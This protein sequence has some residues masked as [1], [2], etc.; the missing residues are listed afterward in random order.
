MVIIAG[1][2]LIAV[3]IKAELISGW[4]KVIHFII[5]LPLGFLLSLPQ[6][7][8]CFFFNFLIALG[9]GSLYGAIIELLQ[10]FV[11]GR[12][13]SFYDEIANILGVGIGLSLGFLKN[14]LKKAKG[15]KG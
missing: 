10:N 12:T 7:A 15:K 9:F 1:G 4:D 2:S 6:I 5:Y 8:S 3:P 13:P 11:P 14:G